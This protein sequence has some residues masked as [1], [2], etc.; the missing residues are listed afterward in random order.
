M[1]RN[2]VDVIVNCYSLQIGIGHLKLGDVNFSYTW[3]KNWIETVDENWLSHQNGQLQIQH[4]QNT[5]ITI[6]FHNNEKPIAI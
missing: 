3:S 6:L 4:T 5:E 2:Y 1:L